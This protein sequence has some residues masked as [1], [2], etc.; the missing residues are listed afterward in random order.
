LS[1]RLSRGWGHHPPDRKVCEPAPVGRAATRWARLLDIETAPLDSHTPAISRVNT[2]DAFCPRGRL[3]NLGGVSG[4][5]RNLS[6]SIPAHRAAV[7][8]S[9]SLPLAYTGPSYRY[10]SA[11]CTTYF[12]Q[13][14]F[15][16]R[17]YSCTLHRKGSHVCWIKAERVDARQMP[18]KRRSRSELPRPLWRW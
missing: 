8:G 7:L 12:W 6:G 15:P 18:E 1:P 16:Y 5:R 9:R 10:A 2:C 17:D 13:C 3:I 4:H 11:G 14:L